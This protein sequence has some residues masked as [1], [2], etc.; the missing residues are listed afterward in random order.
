MVILQSCAHNPSGMD[1]SKEEWRQ[2]AK[3]IK[4]QNLF[5]FFDNSYQ[6]LASG[7][8][9]KDAYAIR[10]FAESGIEMLIAHSYAKN[11][12]LYGNKNFDQHIVF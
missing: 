1:P 4:A 8:P 7:N 12:G 9:K 10:H 3:I 5:V 6:G 11:L 2:L